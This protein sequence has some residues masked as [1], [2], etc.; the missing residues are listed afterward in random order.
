[1]AARLACY[2]AGF[3]SLHSLLYLA[4]PT[5]PPFSHNLSSPLSPVFALYRK[6]GTLLPSRRDEKHF[7][8][9]FR[10]IQTCLLQDHRQSG[11]SKIQCDR[12]IGEGGRGLHEKWIRGPAPPDSKSHAS[13]DKFNI[14]SYASCDGPDS[15]CSQPKSKRERVGWGGCPTYNLN[16]CFRG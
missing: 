4:F 14:K 5:P 6:L 1:M 16:P 3:L 15:K 9:S 2:I 12:W 10:Y 8:I 11:G 7:K 13:R